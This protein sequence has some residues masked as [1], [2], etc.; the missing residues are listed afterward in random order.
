MY[1]QERISYYKI[2]FQVYHMPFFKLFTFLLKSSAKYKSKNCSLHNLCSLTLTFA[3]ADEG[4]LSLLRRAGVRSGLPAPF[5]VQWPPPRCSVAAASGTCVIPPPQKR[6]S[7]E[8]R[9]RFPP[10]CCVHS[11][12]HSTQDTVGVRTVC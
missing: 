1:F 4:H 12:R 11:A 10:R 5:R 7:M 2:S 8:A 9:C 3:E 6:G